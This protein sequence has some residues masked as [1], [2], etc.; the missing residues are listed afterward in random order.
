[1]ESL[2]QAEEILLDDLVGRLQVRPAPAAAGGHQSELLALGCRRTHTTRLDGD[3]RHRPSLGIRNAGPRG[4][5]HH[6]PIQCHRHHDRRD[7]TGSG[8]KIAFGGLQQGIRDGSGDRRRRGQDDRVG[9]DAPLQIRLRDP[10]ADPLPHRLE[11]L[12]DGSQLRRLPGRQRLRQIRETRAQGTNR[13]VAARDVVEKE[14]DATRRVW[15]AGRRVGDEGRYPAV[16]DTATEVEAGELRDAA[17]IEAC[18]RFGSI[19]I[20]DAAEAAQDPRQAPE[21]QG[22]VEADAR[23]TRNAQHACGIDGKALPAAHLGEAERPQGKETLFETCRSDPPQQ[24]PVVGAHLVGAGIEAESLPLLAGRPSS[25]A[26]GALQYRHLASALVQ[27]P[28]GGQSGDSRTNHGD[29]AVSLHFSPARY[30]GRG[31]GSGVRPEPGRI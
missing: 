28:G 3:R 24:I 20:E 10:H 23:K 17:I 19:G 16:Q 6:G 30:C 5:A 31:P 18:G 15:I 1:M 8:Q 14:E 11:C 7:V 2:K 25:H 13:C 4:T 21:A 29:V 26:V 27:P 9:V 12:D 22:L